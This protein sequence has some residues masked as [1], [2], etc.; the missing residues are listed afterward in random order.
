MRKL[1]NLDFNNLKVSDLVQTSVQ[2]QLT[3]DGVLNRISYED[4]IKSLHGVE[5][6]DFQQ[7]LPGTL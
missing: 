6:F 4:R 5:V 2:D 7:G 1:P 3:A